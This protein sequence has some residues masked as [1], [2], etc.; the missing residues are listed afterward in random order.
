MPIYI[1]FAAP[2][3]NLNTGKGRV[4]KMSF[5]NLTVTPR[6]LGN[7]A[8]HVANEIP[9]STGQSSAQ[10][11]QH[12][13]LVISKEKN[14]SSPQLFGALCTNEVLSSVEL[15]FTEGNPKGKEQVVA[16]IKLTN[17]TISGYKT[18]HGVIV[19]PK[20]QPKLGG[21]VSRPR[22]QDLEEFQL[23]FESIAITNVSKSKSTSDD[24]TA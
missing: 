4:H 23:V 7:A 12:Q 13:P 10:K 11:S 1:Q 24:W 2:A 19:P 14:A 20:Y 22:T 18:Y 16:T 9:G 8:F 21:G 5:G 15:N 6:N 17:A 3:I